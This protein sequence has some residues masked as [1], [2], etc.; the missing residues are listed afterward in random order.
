[1]LLLL[2]AG[3]SGDPAT[4][5]LSEGTKARVHHPDDP[6]RALAELDPLHGNKP[7]IALVPDGTDVVILADEGE[8]ESR[9]VRL[10]IVE[11]EYRGRTTDSIYRK[12]VR[13]VR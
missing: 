5:R 8:G 9:R 6:R 11:G 1:L 12:N 13:P 7:D 4:S 3:C 2:T 10:K